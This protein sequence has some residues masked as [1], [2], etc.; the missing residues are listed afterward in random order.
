VASVGDDRSATKNESMPRGEPKSQ[1]IFLGDNRTPVARCDFLSVGVVP[2]ESGLGVKL[3]RKQC[4]AG[5]AR[6]WRELVEG[7]M[8][9]EDEVR[10]RVRSTHELRCS[11]S[12]VGLRPSTLAGERLVVSRV[13]P[14]ASPD[15]TRDQ[16]ERA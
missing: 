16:S 3:D 14:Q 5:G 13:P 9:P 7:R 1:A 6:T 12:L 2:A 11:A 10:G 8:Q 15:G 4:A